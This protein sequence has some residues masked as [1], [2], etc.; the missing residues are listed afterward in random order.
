MISYA[1][2]GYA[3]SDVRPSGA[4]PGDGSTVEVAR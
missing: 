1:L 2:T 3:A 4:L